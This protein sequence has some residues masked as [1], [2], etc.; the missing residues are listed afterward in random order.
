M[1]GSGRGQGAPGGDRSPPVRWWAARPPAREPA[2]PQ[3]SPHPPQAKPLKLGILKGPKRPSVTRDLHLRRN[4]PPRGLSAT[5]GAT[6]TPL[7]PD[8]TPS[9]SSS[10]PMGPAAFPPRPTLLPPLCSLCS[11]GEPRL[12]CSRIPRLARAVFQKQPLL[13][14][15]EPPVAS[16][17]PRCPQTCATGCGSARL[18]PPRLP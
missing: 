4:I 11:W 6:H 17:G 15:G 7:E 13:Q 5:P 2:Q 10:R 12:S 8:P 9:P 18:G 1:G 3:C 16:S 14:P